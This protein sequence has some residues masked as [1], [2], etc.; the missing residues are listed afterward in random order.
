MLL[1]GIYEDTGS[2]TYSRTTPRDV[3]GAAFLLEA[4][5]NLEI[6][7]RFLNPPLSLEQRAVY[8]LLLANAQLHQIH[9]YRVVV[10]CGAAGGSGE[11]ISSLSHKLPR[12]S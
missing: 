7:A 1:L 2:L 3:R 4:G 8:D 12:S 9:G 6:M 11:E 5:A 10:T